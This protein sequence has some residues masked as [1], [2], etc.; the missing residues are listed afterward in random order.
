MGF[1]VLGK[2]QVR[3]SGDG[4]IL[5]MQTSRDQELVF[6]REEHEEHDV[7]LRTDDGQ[8]FS[9]YIKEIS[10][11]LAVCALTLQAGDVLHFE[12]VFSVSE[13]REDHFSVRKDFS[14]GAGLGTKKKHFVR[15]S[16]VRP[17]IDK[18]R[19]IPR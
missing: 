18:G 4:K 6:T 7:T 13:L 8:R 1:Q 2:I 15:I 5:T 10:G 11:R 3:R 14:N 9:L 19:Q 12:E 16:D 17:H